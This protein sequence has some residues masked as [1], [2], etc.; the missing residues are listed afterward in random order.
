MKTYN[1]LPFR[2]RK[3]QLEYSYNQTARQEELLWKKE[4][5]RLEKLKSATLQRQENMTDKDR[6]AEE[7]YRRLKEMENQHEQ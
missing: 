5:E 7:A 6:E 1:K 2:E 4:I 3:R